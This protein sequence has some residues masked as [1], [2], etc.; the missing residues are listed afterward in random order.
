M[1]K[2]LG[3]TL[4]I[5]ASIMGSLSSFAVSAKWK[6]DKSKNLMWIE[7]GVKVKGWKQI[8]GK[9]YNFRED[10]I[11]RTGWLKD[12]ENWY[13]LWSDGTMAHNSWLTNGGFW[14]Y[15]DESGKMVTNS[16]TVENKKYDFNAPAIIVSEN[17]STD[18]NT[19]NVMTSNGGK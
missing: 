8:D 19:A 17:V 15:F 14:Y 12:N 3:V 16:V 10:G 18:N 4:L 6:E 11:M 2:R 7:N 9:W 13:Y 5:V 1:M